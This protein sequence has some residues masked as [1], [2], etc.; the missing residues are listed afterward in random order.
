MLYCKTP[1]R[2]PWT[3]T[4]QRPFLEG[5]FSGGGG[6]MFGEVHTRSKKQIKK[7]MGL[8]IQGVRVYVNEY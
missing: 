8:F 7:C 3:C 2:S 1:E 4:F 6:P 5:L